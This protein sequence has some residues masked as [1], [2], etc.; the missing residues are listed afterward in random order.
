MSGESELFVVPLLLGA[1]AVYGGAKLA[2]GAVKGT[3]AAAN[4]A[5]DAITDAIQRSRV[6]SVER[7]L[8]ALS[9]SV[10]ELDHKLVQEMNAARAEALAE[11]SASVAE[12]SETCSKE[13]DMSAFVD[14]CAASMSSL[15]A[16]MAQKRNTLEKE[17][18][19]RINEEVKVNTAELKRK[20]AM[21]TES[22][23]RISDDM[24]KRE[25]FSK[26]ASDAIASAE[27]M[28]NAIAERYKESPKCSAAVFE[29]RQSL[30]SAKQSFNDGL[31]EAAFISAN[32]VIDT[33]NLRIAELAEHEMKC[34]QRF[35]DVKTLSDTVSSLFEKFA[36]ASYTVKKKDGDK[37]VEV[38]NFNEYYRGSYE[39]LSD[40]FQNI[41]SRINSRDFRAFLPEELE[42]IAEELSTLQTDFLRETNLAFERLD[43]ERKRKKTAKSL[44]K[45]YTEKRGYELI[46][47]TDEEMKISSLDSTILK[48]RTPET[49]DTVKMKLN[50]VLSGDRIC[51][52][53]DIEDRTDYEGSIAEVELQREE[54]R[55]K[56]CSTIRKTYGEKSNI[57]HRCKNPGVRY[58]RS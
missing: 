53:V 24:E 10:N 51:M 16:N 4:A 22:I 34:S 37:T 58:N 35:V 55:D 12:I 46:P 3:A 33:V 23:E 20:R 40:K 29:C 43:T 2:A 56:I 11:Y 18:I 25:T 48:F 36:K 32:S 17:Y 44:I 15:K 13:G 30:N 38:D 9:N 41:K 7:K 52:T 31:Y 5:A 45:E 1:A 19:N 42:D 54:E 47:L 57:K 8:G 50:S 21:V 49:G 6:N 27:D 39:A 28:V 14:K 26:N